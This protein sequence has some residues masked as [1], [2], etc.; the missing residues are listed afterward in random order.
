[1]RRSF[2]LVLLILGLIIDLS[3]Q[4]VKVLVNQQMDVAQKQMTAGDYQAANK[5][6]RKIL[7]LKTV[8]PHDLSYLFAETLF[9]V[10]QYENSNNFLERYFKLT[11]KAGNYTNQAEELELL[12]EIKLKEIRECQY[13][14]IHG[15]RLKICSRCHGEKYVYEK[16][17]YCNGHGKLICH[18]CLGEGVL[19]KKNDF[20]IDEYE[21]CYNCEGTGIEIC[22]V[23]KGEKILKQKCPVCLGTG[24]ESTKIICDH[25]PPE[26]G[27]GFKF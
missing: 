23:C 19:I 12:L 2:I 5:T 21:T 15:Y 4:D 27:E 13:C 25:T 20:S 22:P 1:M 9:M 24:Y 7:A 11:G 17:Y 3:G 10:G 16:C 6:F 8:L 26:E 18:V 14:D